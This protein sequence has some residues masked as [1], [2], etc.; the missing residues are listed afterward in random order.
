[1]QTREQPGPPAAAGFQVR[2]TRRHVLRQGL[3]LEPAAEARLAARDAWDVV[4][5]GHG[6]LVDEKL[7]RGDHAHAVGRDE[8]RPWR[9]RGRRPIG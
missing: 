1:M 5:L 8:R 6:R 7:A 9:R 4:R 2:L 3:P